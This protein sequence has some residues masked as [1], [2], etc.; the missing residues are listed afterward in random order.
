LHLCLVRIVLFEKAAGKLKHGCIQRHIHRFLGLLGQLVKADRPLNGIGA[1]CGR[2]AR[3]KYQRKLQHAPQ[4]QSF[5]CSTSLTANWASC[6]FD[7]AI[8]IASRSCCL[9]ACP[10]A[11]CSCSWYAI[12]PVITSRAASTGTS[13][14]DRSFCKKPPAAA[15]LSRSY[16]LAPAS[17][18]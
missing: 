14:H 12:P 17:T 4:S 10:L 9:A 6:S 15:L 5:H 8:C 1:P 11:S 13:R 7:P 18:R 16:W 3:R 2:H